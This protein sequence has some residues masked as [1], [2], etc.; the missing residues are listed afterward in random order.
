MAVRFSH[1]VLTRSLKNPKNPKGF[2]NTAA[3]PLG[4]IRKGGA[5]SADFG[6]VGASGQKDRETL[7]GCAAGGTFTRSTSPSMTSVPSGLPNGLE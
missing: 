3:P 4:R 1:R 7:A 6:D 2:S 5:P